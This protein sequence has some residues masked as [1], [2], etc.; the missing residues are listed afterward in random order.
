MAFSR[1]RNILTLLGVIKINIVGLNYKISINKYNP[2]TWAVILFVALL[3]ASIAAKKE[4][5]RFFKQSIN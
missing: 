5:V 2:L 3:S 1:C 4:F